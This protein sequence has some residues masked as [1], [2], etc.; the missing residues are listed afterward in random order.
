M[1]LTIIKK[2]RLNHFILP[3][4]LYGSYWITDYENGKI[5]NLI[6]VEAERTGWRLISN[7]DVFIVDGKD[8][9]IPSVSLQ[10]NSFYL[11]KNNYK[12]DRY[13]LYCSDINDN[14][15]RELGIQDKVTVGSGK[16]CTVCYNLNTIP[17][18][19]FEIVK[20]DKYYYINVHDTKTYVYL[21]QIRVLTTKRLEYGDT[22]FIFGLKIILMKRSGR[23][24]ILVNNPNNLLNFSASFANVSTVKSAFVDDHVEL[25]DD[26]FYKDDDYFYRAP[27]F[28]N[29]FDKYTLDIDPPPQPRTDEEMPTVLT[30]VP[31]LTMSMSSIVSMASSLSHGKDDAINV[32]TTLLTSGA[33]LVS[34]LVWPLV[35]KGYTKLSNRMYER[36]RESKYSKYLKEKEKEV[37]SEME[38]QKIYLRENSL[39]VT[40]AQNVIINKNP[41]LWQRR[42]YDEDFLTLP[43]GLGEMPMQIDVNFPEKHFSLDFDTLLEKARILGLTPRVLD[44]VPVTYSFFKARATG[45][46]GDQMTNKEF[47]DRIVIEMIANYSYD[48]LKIVTLTSPDNE[49]GWDYIKIIPHSWSNDKSIRFFGSQNDDYKEII[50]NLEKIYNERL[51]QKDSTTYVPHYVIITDAV[52]SISNFDF[53]KQIMQKEECGFSVIMLVDKL[54]VLPNECTSFINVTREES[55]ILS[56]VLNKQAKRFRID[57]SPIDDLY[58]CAVTLANI[59]MD[60]KSEVEASLPD[61]YQFLEMYQVGKVEQLN[62]YDRWRKNNPILSLQ[63]PIGIGK[64]GEIITLDLHEKYHGPHGL[65]AGTTGSGKSEFIITYILSLAVNYH[66]S[67]VQVIL[68]DYKGGSLAGAFTNDKYRLPHLVGTI[69]NLDGNEL[70]RSLA[71]IESEVKR[72]QAVFN[73]AR[74]IANES[75]VD[76]Y[77][78]QKLYRE[79]RLKDMEPIAHLFIISDEFA[80]LKEQQPEFME[81]LISVARVGRSLGVHLILA[82]QKPGGVVDSQ[83][84]SNTRFRVSLKVQDVGDSQ[85]VLKKPDAAYLKKTGR[86]YL[87]VGFDEVFTL[88][89]SAWAGGQYYPNTTFKKDIDTSVSALNNIGM[90]LKSK[91]DEVE[92]KSESVG[93]ELPYIVKYL[94]ELAERQHIV[95]RKLWL[96]KIPEKIYIDNLKQKYNYRGQPYYLTPIIGEY[97]DPMSQNQ[98]ALTMP[99]S[100]SGNALIFG[101]T[102]SGKEMLLQGL[103]YSSMTTYAPEEVNFYIIDFGAETLRAFKDSPYVGDIVLVNENDKI[104]NLFALVFKEL[105]RRKKSFAA[106]DGN[107]QNYIAKSEEKVPNIV[108]ILNNYEAFEENYD[109]LTDAVA[110]IT[111]EAFKYGIYFVLTA[112]SENSIRYKVRQNFSLIYVLGHGDSSEY[113]ILGNTRGKTPAKYKG[114]GLFKRDNIYEFQTARITE[115]NVSDFIRAYSAKI[116]NSTKYRAKKVPVLPE[117]VDYESLKEHLDTAKDFIIGIEKRSLNPVEYSFK[118]NIMNCIS[119]YE[120]ANTFNFVNALIDQNA[121]RKSYEVILV[122]TT[123]TVFENPNLKGKLVE[124]QFDDLVSNL[125]EFI[126][127]VYNQYEK[128]KFD[129]NILTKQKKYLVFIYGITDFINKLSPE[130]QER[131]TDAIGKDMQMSIISFVVIDNPDAIKNF[132]YDTWFKLGVDLSRGIWIGSGVIDQPLFKVTTYSRDD[133]AE[134]PPEF[135]YNINMGK[136][137]RIKMLANFK[138]DRESEKEK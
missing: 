101:S 77:K 91:D 104:I 54:S 83:I 119:S 29:T 55:A 33:M 134:I 42:V 34:T 4:Q 43:V 5:L 1:Q 22:I 87:Q 124:K 90:I 109:G 113:S 72:R 128:S 30:V 129:E 21:N 24:Y 10:N 51:A 100:N 61:T 96:D 11:L 125:S 79:G 26:T 69:T 35:M 71:S 126:S 81:K 98:F 62:S 121:Y 138:P 39:S 108:V 46:V 120:I 105:E 123:E 93:E 131:L 66:P 2:S 73:E 6:N 112:N 88:G 82:T 27:H 18:N 25:P 16:S 58:N 23:D 115:T 59:P 19:A 3:E 67:E 68:I 31:M 133:R 136:V 9:P 122:N 52:K 36:K 78:Y 57:F 38:K 48:E 110:Q 56:S 41:K 132:A 37:I 14:S 95:T 135:G 97:D 47:I 20:K 111:R 137:S 65:I 99:L 94:S 107:Y 130:S 50:Y 127:Q 13:Y 114:R 106:F 28:Y 76:I 45:I 84:W 74:K 64:S 12:N 15:Y 53:I 70:N 86:F 32:G 44:D 63:A 117:V 75:T 116:K 17:K 40:E 8:T 118:K 102:G 7:Q 103:I 92:V 89:Q 85:E 80:E 60:V 49:S